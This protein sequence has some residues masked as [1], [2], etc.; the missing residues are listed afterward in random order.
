MAGG[1]STTID[2]LTVGVSSDTDPSTLSVTLTETDVDTGVFD[3]TLTLDESSET[4]TSPSTI[5]V[6][7]PSPFNNDG[8]TITAAGSCV[9]NA[10]AEY[11]TSGAILQS[12]LITGPNEFPLFT[13][14]RSF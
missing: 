6:T 5:A 13:S 9:S 1:G 12:A 4:H 11:D 3:V 2:T 7:D 8:D 10:T 14:S